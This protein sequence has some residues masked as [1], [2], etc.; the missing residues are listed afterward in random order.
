MGKQAVILGNDIVEDLAKSIPLYLDRLGYTR[1]ALCE[2]GVDSGPTVATW[3]AAMKK[4]E[5]PA[6]HAHGCPWRRAVEQVRLDKL[7]REVT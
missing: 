4:M 1:C 3:V 7:A 6:G 2:Q 5:N